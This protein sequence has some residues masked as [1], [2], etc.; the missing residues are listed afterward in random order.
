MLEN[1]YDGLRAYRQSKLAMVMFGFDG[2]LRVHANPQ[3]Y[4]RAARAQFRALSEQLTGIPKS[5]QDRRA[6]RAVLSSVLQI[7]SLDGR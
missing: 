4:D 1:G 6:N 3:A 2:K 7:R 5:E